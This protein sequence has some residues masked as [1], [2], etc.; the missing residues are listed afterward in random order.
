MKKLKQIVGVLIAG[1][2]LVTGVAVTEMATVDTA[3]ARSG[4]R[5]CC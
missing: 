2:L 1:L 5:P 4:P 3:V